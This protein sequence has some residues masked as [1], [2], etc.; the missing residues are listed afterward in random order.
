VLVEPRFSA[1]LAA[2][3]AFPWEVEQAES[4]PLEQPAELEAQSPPPSA[5][6]RGRVQSSGGSGIAGATVELRGGT[7]PRRVVAD[8]GG[9]FAVDDLAPGSYQMSVT[10]EGWTAYEG[11]I[12]LRAGANPPLELALKRELP[13]AQ[14]RGTVRSF[15]GAPLKASIL[16]PALRIEQSSRE[17]GTFELD[18]APGE[19][20]I[21]VKAKGF[22]SQTRRARVEQNGV[23]ILIVEL[24]PDRR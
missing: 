1:G 5:A 22:Q 16:V 24:Q 11:S 14:I 23:A 9:D 20:A 19:Y 15:G 12:E 10:A 17:D 13:Q 3:L 6:V 18:V 21:T 8:A 7:E 4:S 2:A